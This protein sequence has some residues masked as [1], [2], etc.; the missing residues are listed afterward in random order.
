M[1]RGALYATLY[2]QQTEITRH[3]PMLDAVDRLLRD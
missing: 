3:A 2:R 1:A